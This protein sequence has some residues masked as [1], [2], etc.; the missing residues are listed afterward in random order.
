MW[1]WAE[2]LTYYKSDTIP[3]KTQ[4]NKEVVRA[5]AGCRVQGRCSVGGAGG[6]GSGLGKEGARGCG[7]SFE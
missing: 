4:H 2:W 1:E 7:A 5:G 6:V 3:K